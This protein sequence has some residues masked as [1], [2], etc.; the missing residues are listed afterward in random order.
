MA[1][2]VRGDHDLMAP[3]PMTTMPIKEVG[4]VVGD[5]ARYGVPAL[6][7]FAGGDRRDA[8]G[9]RGASADSIMANAIREAKSANPAVTVMTETCL[10][11]YTDS[12]ECHIARKD[13]QPDLA[14]TLEA[15]AA[16]AVV[17]A[18]AGADIIGPAAMLAGSIAR[19]RQALDETG[20]H[21]VAVMPHLIFDSRLYEGYRKTMDAVPA[22]GDR[23]PFQIDPRSPMAAVDSALGFISEGAR[24]LLLEPALFCA[25]VLI[26]L[27]R[28]CDVQL[29]PFSVS[30]E[31]LRL[32]G[33]GDDLRLMLELFTFLKR[34]GS[35]QIIT[36]AAADM[37]RILA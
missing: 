34:S 35:E 17:Q 6:K 30:G 2:L 4:S 21:N 8:H 33:F 20:H 11:S 29:S 12:G 13:G 23:R 14:A 15:M 27:K 5:L 10:C 3:R 24:M 37:A 7:V 22:S 31:Y 18:D 36:Y 9:S 1:I 16:Q 28:A 32:T 26:M 19:I 25:D